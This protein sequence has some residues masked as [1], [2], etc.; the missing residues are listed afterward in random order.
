MNRLIIDHPDISENQNTSLT[1]Q[2]NAGNTVLNVVNTKGFSTNQILLIGNLGSENAEIIKTHATTAPTD[3]TITLASALKFNHTTDEPITLLDYDKIE[4]QR[5]SSKGGTYSVIDTIDI[6]VDEDETTYKDAAGVSTDYYRFRY[7]NSID[8]SYSDYSVEIPASGYPSN[9]LNSM[10]EKVL[11]LFSSQSE[12]LLNRDE[13]IEDINEGYRI[14]VNKIID[15]G[16]DY[17][18]KKGDQIPLVANQEEYTLPTDFVRPKRIYISYDGSNEYPAEPMDF[19]LEQSKTAYLEAEPKYF[20]R[21]EKIVIRPV[22]TSSTGYIQPYYYYMPNLLTNDDDEPELPKGYHNL[23]VNYALA[24][25]FEK[26][27]KIDW[28]N[29][30]MGLFTNQT[31]LMLLEIKKRTP[32]RGQRIVPFGWE[33]DDNY[34]FY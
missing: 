10:V 8:N 29:Y 6:A 32:E 30:Y 34:P 19:I 27:K 4:I 9:A 18:A 20:F 3:T 1:Q 22:P 16:I 31:E 13:I 23:L 7:K 14:L 2:A 25:A 24:R 11:T 21:G 28:V 5:A 26:D 33:Y 15:L 17:Y 12:K